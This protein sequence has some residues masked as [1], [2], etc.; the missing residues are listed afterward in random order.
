MLRWNTPLDQVEL[1]VFTAATIN[2]QNWLV[3]RVFVRKWLQVMFPAS[4]IRRFPA[5]LCFISYQR[6]C[7]LVSRWHETYRD[8]SFDFEKLRRMFFTIFFIN[9][10][11]NRWI[12][13]NIRKISWLQPSKSLLFNGSFNEFH[14][15]NTEILNKKP[16]DAEILVQVWWRYT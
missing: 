6:K 8:T 2:R 16:V 13:R 11:I 1:K 4:Q 14:N 5:F 10:T 12:W 7:L 15:V 9:Q 3:G